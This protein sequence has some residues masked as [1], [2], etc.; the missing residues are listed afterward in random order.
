MIHYDDFDA[1]ERLYGYHIGG[2][3]PR[4]RPHLYDE[5]RAIEARL[6]LDHGMPRQIAM[7]DDEDDL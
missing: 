5:K 3:R 7:V 4:E 2:Y 1:E 6:N